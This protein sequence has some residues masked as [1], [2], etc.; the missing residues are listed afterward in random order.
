MGLAAKLVSAA[1]LRHWSADRAASG[2]SWGTNSARG[3]T[4]A[5]SSPRAWRMAACAWRQ[6]RWWIASPR[7]ATIFC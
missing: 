6:A 1:S 7:A 3:Q 2:S 5:S 4:T